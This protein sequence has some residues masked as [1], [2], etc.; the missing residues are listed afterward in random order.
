MFERRHQPPPGSGLHVCP[1]CRMDFVVPVWWEHV[2]DG[3][4]R[5]LLRCGE[6]ETHHDLVVPGDVADRF[7]K[8]YARMLAAMATV[9][10]RLDRERMTTQASAF[11]TALAR[12]L[13]G[14]D[15][16]RT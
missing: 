3:A 14:A 12:D 16:F 10:D 15:D 7:E 5:L 13:I 2:E 6:C 9:L 11:A 4:L 1:V 8:D